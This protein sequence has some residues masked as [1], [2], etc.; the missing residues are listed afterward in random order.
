MTSPSH[1]S[2]RDFLIGST[3]F[4]SKQSKP[5]AWA[6][7]PLGLPDTKASGQ[8]SRDSIAPGKGLGMSLRSRPL[9]LPPAGPLPR[10]W[11]TF[12]SPFPPYVLVEIPEIAEVLGCRALVLGPDF[13]WA[14]MQRMHPK[15][16]PAW[17]DFL[18]WVLRLLRQVLEASVMEGTAV[19]DKR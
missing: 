6:G 13:G 14:S 17:S 11:H 15:P 7:L 5:H 8:L 16:S 2:Y 18:H 12:P 19:G 9:L 1:Q 10:P 4:P 3:V